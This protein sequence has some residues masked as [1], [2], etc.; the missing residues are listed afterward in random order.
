MGTL[1]AA[2]KGK[3]LLALA[4]IGGAAAAALLARLIPKLIGKYAEQYLERALDMRNAEDRELVMAL[5]K[6][7]EKKIPDAGTGKEKYRM[8]AAKIVRMLP[9]MKNHEERIG[10]MIEDAVSK[11]DKELKET[12][13]KG[14]K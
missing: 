2:I 10:Q 5:V 1:I 4:G 11:L 14:G 6:F 9:V 12:V 13:K 8:V 7:A 3:A